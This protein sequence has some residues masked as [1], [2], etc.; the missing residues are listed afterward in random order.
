MKKKKIILDK[1][2]D[3]SKKK[4]TKNKESRE[5][6]ES[7]LLQYKDVLQYSSSR[8]DRLIDLLSRSS[9]KKWSAKKKEKMI[10]RHL[11]AA[12]ESSFAL[13]TIDQAEFRLSQIQYDQ[14]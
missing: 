8:L 6:L 4:E 13:S 2:E 7:L 12:D 10:K 14:K 11:A 1:K 3:G 5:V 9:A